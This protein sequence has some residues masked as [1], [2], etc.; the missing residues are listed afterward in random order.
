MHADGAI[1]AIID[2]DDQQIRAILRRRCQFLSV[3]QEIAVSG[4][5]NH[6]AFGEAYGG[7]D[8]SGDA[9][10]HGPGGGGQLAR[11]VAIAPVTMPP[12]GKIAR[13]VADDGVRRIALAHRLH[14]KAK[15]Q[16]CAIGLRIVPRQ[17]FG[18]GL[19]ARIE[20]VEF[21]LPQRR[22]FGEL[23]HAR[24]DRQI[25][26]VHA[27]HLVRIR[28]DMH[29]Y[30]V[31]MVGRDHRIA[32]GR[33]LAQ[34][35]AHGNHQIG[36]LDTLDQLGVRAI[37]QIAGIDRALPVDRVLPP[38]G[39][40]NGQTQPLGPFGEIV[41]RLGVPARTADNAH[42]VGRLVQQLDQRQH[43]IGA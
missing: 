26:A 42:R 19:R 12:A 30:L 38:E 8:G 23:V 4:H 37:A 28:V 40:G 27:V 29:Q 18:M 3:H 43:G 31:R 15:V 36:R 13:A 1:A 9:I 35:R 2:H 33:R 22:L 41:P 21:I 34:P 39:G 24:A 6:R 11:H 10:A 5:R 7:S 25:G 20:A 14:T 32:V 16:R 17:P